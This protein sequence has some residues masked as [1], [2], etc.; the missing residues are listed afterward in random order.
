MANMSRQ[1][2]TLQLLAQCSYRLCVSTDFFTIMYKHTYFLQVS[3]PL[4]RN[5][6]FNIDFSLRD[7]VTI[8]R[9]VYK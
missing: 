4:F 8:A 6:D 5:F 9:T 7:Y 3:P 2:Q 1:L